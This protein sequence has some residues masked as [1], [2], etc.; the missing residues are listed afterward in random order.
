MS[1]PSLSGGPRLDAA[2]TEILCSPKEQTIYLH[3]YMPAQTW[4]ANLCFSRRA[5]LPRE[6][7]GWGIFAFSPPAAATE[8]GWDIAADHQEHLKRFKT[9]INRNREG[10]CV[11]WQK[12][13]ERETL[14]RVEEEEKLLRLTVSW[15]ISWQSPQLWRKLAGK[16]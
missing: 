11:G 9:V 10:R 15:D 6:S 5:V 1:P 2:T 4:P 16:L 14:E 8:A 7:C 12:P 13:N 3:N